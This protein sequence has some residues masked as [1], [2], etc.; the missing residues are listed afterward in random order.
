M[1]AT[2]SG[3][4][5]LS[6]WRAKQSEAARRRRGDNHEGWHLVFYVF[7][8][9]G[10]CVLMLQVVVTIFRSA[11]PDGGTVFGTNDALRGA[12]A[13]L[14][15]AM[16]GNT[17][18]KAHPDVVALAKRVADA[19]APFQTTYLES[20]GVETPSCAPE[21]VHWSALQPGYL[22]ACP[23]S[24]C[25]M[26][27]DLD[28]AKAA[29]AQ[30]ED[31][32][33]VTKSGESFETRQ[34]RSIVDSEHGEMSAVRSVCKRASNA[35][36]VWE[37]FRETIEQ[38]LDDEEEL[39]LNT[40]YP[41]REDGSIFL[42]I[43]TYRDIT[44]PDTL[45]GAFMSAKNPEKL[46]VGIV[47]QNCNVDNCFTGTGWGNTRKWVH[48][49]GP[50]VDCIEAFCKEFPEVCHKQV[51][52][53]RLGERE[54]YGPFFGRFLNSK[55]YRGENF[56]VQI[57]A[58][59]E[60]RQDWDY[61]LVDQ[62][63]RTPSYPNS[64]ISNYP[65]GGDPRRIGKWPAPT[66]Y[67]EHTPSALCGCN[68]ED[69][70]GTHHTV[71]L[72]ETPR[73][74]SR[75]VDNSVP[76][77]SAFVAAGFFVAHGSIVANVPFD[78]FMP[79]LFMGEEISLTIRF[80]TSGYDIYGPAIN[81]L[82]HEYVRKESPKFWE[83]VTMVFKNGGIHNSLTDLIIPRVQHLVGWKDEPARTESVF[84]RADQFG[85][86]TKR[87]A[88]QFVKVMQIRVRSLRQTAP[89][90]CVHGTDMPAKLA[91]WGVSDD[92]LDIEVME[93]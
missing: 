44:C 49:E 78:P 23:K 54:S 68:F 45:K 18:P 77:H 86:G 34:S 4:S 71:R 27:T 11:E 46:F 33:G 85:C 90:W 80:W 87:S 84:A 42:A 20:I 62:M 72:R 92:S 24:G 36:E 26:F 32:G 13:D 81:V 8:L 69:A 17:L 93:D 75:D 6:H 9:G 47:Q 61:W 15:N 51:K 21:H 89:S 48:Q 22:A 10:L 79:Y 55:L 67:N 58:H 29:C 70:G 56:Y 39:H 14:D 38:A 30:E 31:C 7:G 28:E 19:L 25:R 37:A 1:Q 82:R 60:F 65:P 64:V 53:L 12:R 66:G 59:T 63:K 40:V 91:Q 35:L 2:R 16:S 83:S 50:D 52:I 3:P 73:T 41:T 74:F 5:K 57:D 43:S 88:L 76:H